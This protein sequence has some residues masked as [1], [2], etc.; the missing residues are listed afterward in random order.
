MHELD[1][2]ASARF[3]ALVLA[4]V[5]SI[6]AC[7]P[8]AP[9]SPATANGQEHMPAYAGIWVTSEPAVPTR[10]VALRLTDPEDPGFERAHTFVSGVALRGS[11]PL[12]SGR[13]HLEGLSGACAL[14]VFLGPERE[15][16]VVVRLEDG[17]GCALTVVGEHGNGVSHDEPS[18]LM[19][20]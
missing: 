1:H 7:A 6:A 15:T 11:I 5:L 17:G 8:V 18:I 4:T 20:P 12:S 14:D 2:P 19:A 10:P 13:Y 3:G 16:D 9:I